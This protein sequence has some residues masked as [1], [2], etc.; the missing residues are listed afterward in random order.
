MKESKI[1]YVYIMTNKMNSVLYVGMTSDIEQRVYD[2]KNKTYKGFTAKYNAN[3]LV[4]YE[5]TDDV[6]FA[7][8]YEKTLKKWLRKWK[9][10]LTGKENSLWEDLA[11][12]WF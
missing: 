1:Y 9:E 3:K 10:E 6:S 7:L 2:H 12:D 5:E 4:Y 11:S 8:Q